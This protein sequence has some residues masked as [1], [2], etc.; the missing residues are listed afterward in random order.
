MNLGN[1]GARELECD[2]IDGREDAEP[3]VVVFMEISQIFATQGLFFLGTIS[4][5]KVYLYNLINGH[6]ENS[7]NVTHHIYIFQ[8]SPPNR[9][10]CKLIT[11]SSIT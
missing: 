10:H 5:D 3:N 4:F 7:K 1:I 2:S 6:L 9:D 11:S 8:I